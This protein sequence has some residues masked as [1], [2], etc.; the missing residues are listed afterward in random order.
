MSAAA[1]FWIEIV[2]GDCA[3]ARTGEF[4]HSRPPIK[5]LMTEAKKDGW[6]VLTSGDWRCPKCTAEVVRKNA[7]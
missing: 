1:V 6:T 7:P 5:A 4:F 2:C 3:V